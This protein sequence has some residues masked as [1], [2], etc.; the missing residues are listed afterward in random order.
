MRLVHLSLI[1][2]KQEA[3]PFSDQSLE[4]PVL[5]GLTL[6]GYDFI[7]HLQ[8]QKALLLKECFSLKILTNQTSIDDPDPNKQICKSQLASMIV[9]IEGSLSNALIV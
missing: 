7:V 2:W 5:K 3:T 6:S 9:N 8:K 4:L 1:L